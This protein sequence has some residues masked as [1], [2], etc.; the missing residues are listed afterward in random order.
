MMSELEMI[1][2]SVIDGG[3]EFYTLETCKH[4]KLAKIVTH[5][6]SRH[7]IYNNVTYHV[8]NADGK[9]KFAHVNYHIAYNYY[10][11][12]IAEVR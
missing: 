12:N 1:A 6:E 7:Q 9:R 11:N 2:K 3:G 5:Y 8:F 10:M 4:G